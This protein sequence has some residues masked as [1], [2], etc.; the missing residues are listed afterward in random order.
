ME[1]WNVLLQ[2]HDLLERQ[3]LIATVVMQILLSAE[4]AI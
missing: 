4:N 1:V 3:P 2:G